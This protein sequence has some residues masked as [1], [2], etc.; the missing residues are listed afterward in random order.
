[1][2][3][4]QIQ[5]HY[6]SAIPARGCAAALLLA[7]F[8]GC[9]TSLQRGSS[10]RPITVCELFKN[11][12]AYR[13]KLVT[14]V[15][16]YWYGLRETCPEPFVTGGHVW[17]SAL[18][19]VHSDFPPGLGEAAPFKTDTESWDRLELFVRQEAMNGRREEIWAT[20][21]GMIRAP[22]S[23]IRTD[24]QIVGGYGHLG[25][26]AAQLVVKSVLNF[27]VKSNA[28]YDYGQLLRPAL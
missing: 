12:S 28:T 4:T 21:V 14:V 10:A 25:G 9:S 15:G 17:P 2:P 23:Y 13:G 22:K 16:I 27:A 8:C 26:Y 1:M 7:S 6:K 11:P 5:R 19:M 24:G 18:D 20:A 3:K